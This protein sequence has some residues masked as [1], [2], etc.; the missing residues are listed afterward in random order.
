MADDDVPRFPRGRFNKRHLP[1]PY[2][3]D[4]SG[5]LRHLNRRT[6]L[7]RA[8]LANDPV[9]AAYLCAGMRLLEKHFGPGA[10][11]HAHVESP[12]LG[13]VSQRVVAAAVSGN[14][15]AFVR[16]GTVAGLRDRWSVHA[17]FIAD[18]INF[19]VWLEN[20]RPGYREQRVGDTEQLV[21]GP[22]LAAAVLETAYRHT[23]E[24]LDTTS[25]RFSLA[26]MA[27][28]AGD[29]VVRE[30]IDGVYR[31]YLAS[32]KELYATVIKER[33]LRLRPGLTLD[34]LANALS[35]AADGTILR[36]MGD[37][38]AGVVDHARRRSLMGNLALAVILAFLEP[39]EDAGGL[40]LE[41]AVRARFEGWMP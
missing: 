4:L 6:R 9:T 22:D 24:G 18:L 15:E 40:T 36:A 11:E 8:R 41:Q 21:N 3:R 33:G 28:G 12:L 16:I 27:G 37:P 5:V 38:G 20:Y 25:V 19:A 7:G 34:D 17:D 1:E 35:A 30:A 29:D 31:G 23:A 39:E 10:R 2:N 13:F 14:P 26:L 32:W